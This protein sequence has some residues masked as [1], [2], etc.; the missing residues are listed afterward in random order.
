MGESRSTTANTIIPEN[1]N[2]STENKKKMLLEDQ[3]ELDRLSD[4][5]F[6]G[7]RKVAEYNI[8][9][10]D[11]DSENDVRY[12]ADITVKKEILKNID[13]LSS[14][15]V[16]STIDLKNDNIVLHKVNP[17]IKSQRCKI[18]N[19]YYKENS[20]TTNFVRKKV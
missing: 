12:M 2:L 4:S 15:D 1:S 6:A 5:F 9:G 10:V 7:M 11:G 20:Y 3:A 8:E 13:E 19:D 18:L 16:I 14:K 17:Y